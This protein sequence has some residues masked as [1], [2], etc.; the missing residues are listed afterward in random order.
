MGRGGCSDGVTRKCAGVA[1]QWPMWRTRLG[2]VRGECSVQKQSDRVKD[3]SSITYICAQLDSDTRGRALG[4]K[5]RA[6]EMWS[7]DTVSKYRRIC[8]RTRSCVK[9]SAKMRWKCVEDVPYVNLLWLLRWVRVTR[10]VKN[11]GWGWAFGERN[12][13]VLTF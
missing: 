7:V 10:V 2:R 11:D 13:F 5:A 6:E 3:H 1:G 9:D 4:G 8:E 12:C